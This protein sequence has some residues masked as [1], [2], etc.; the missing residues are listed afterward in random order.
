MSSS[1]PGTNVPPVSFPG[2]ASGIDY[3]SIITKLTSLTLAPT[4][5]L[6]QQMATLNA[7]N[8]E[9]IKINGM[10]ASLQNALTPLSQ[11]ELYGAFSATS[12]D[13]NAAGAQTVAGSPAT[14]GT[15]VIQQTQLA[16]ATQ[17]L[18]NP[19]VGHSETDAIDS[20]PVAATSVPFAQS[21]A[22]ITPQNGTNG[23][24]QVTVDGVTINYDV[25]SQSLSTILANIQSQVRAATGDASFTVSLGGATGDVVS[26]TSNN[27]IS[28]GS[29]S[30]SGNL[31]SALRLDQAQVDNTP[32]AA[33]VT[34]TAG[35]GGIN[36]G[37]TLNASNSSGYATNAGFTTAVT[38]GS[39]TINGVQISVDPTQDNLADVLARINSSAAGVLASYNQSTGQISLT[40]KASGPQGI[41]LGAGSDSSNF[42]AAAGLTGAGAQ[43]IVGTQAKVVLQTPSGGTQTYY[44]NSNNV[45]TAI[46]GV[47]LESALQ[48]RFA[49]RG[50]RF[51][52]QLAAGERAQLVRLSVQH[53]SQR[54]R[55]SD[56]AASGYRASR[57]AAARRA[58]HATAR[59]RRSLGK[60]GRR[61]D[62]RSNREHRF[63]AGTRR[64]KLV[65]F[66]RLNRVATRQLVYDSGAKQL[67]RQR[68][69]DVRARFKLKRLAGPPDSLS[70]SMP[71]SCKPHSLR[72][73]TPC[74]I[75]YRARRASSINWEPI[76]PASRAC[77]PASAADCSE[78]F[79]RS[80]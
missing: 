39:F 31:L 62:S 4:V 32:G 76:S 74:R 15:Y 34:G 65:Q 46:P 3:N 20:P 14:A 56:C 58:K 77:R 18:G 47:Q 9:L 28:L 59:R 64:R 26:I 61:D 5:Q 42:L 40:N 29:A 27:P 79:L 60:R 16:T 25:N 71:R 48:H 22:A 19:G 78:R 52:G 36:Q 53:R 75:Y 13:P 35:V 43:T 44:S 37:Q 72:I 45:T 49:V 30:D 66:A 57:T 33:S 50:Y 80:R 7:A 24:G 6:N 69:L 51:P 17:V 11:A 63:G 67:D 68:R 10:L 12:S 55:S 38:A 70:R 8:A 73:P 1:I 41:V 23:N 54:N 21:Y 2:I